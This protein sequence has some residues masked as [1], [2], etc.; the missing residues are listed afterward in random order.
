MPELRFAAD[1]R[2]RMRSVLMRKGHDVATLLAAVLAGDDGGPTVQALM[3]DA[4][5]GERP[6]ERLRRYLDLLESRRKLLD[7]GDDA[8]GRCD[9]CGQD[10]G[11]LQLIEM[12]WADACPRHAG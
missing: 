2:E 6:A 5:P 11:Q 7:A 4:R 8:F 9:V 1:V 12:P 10:L 3:A